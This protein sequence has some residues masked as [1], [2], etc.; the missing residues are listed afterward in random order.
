MPSR[1]RVAIPALSSHPQAASRLTERI[2]VLLADDHAVL[3]Q[4]TAELLRREPDLE[5]VGEAAD[6]QQAVELT[7]SLLPDVVVM[8]VRMP[9]LSGIQATRLIR[10][11][12]PKT[13]VLVLTAHEDDEY[14]FSLLREGA[15]GYLLKTSPVQE[16]ISAIRLVHHGESPLDP[17][18]A[19]KLVARMVGQGD[20]T[21]SDESAGGSRPLLT[22]REMQVLELVARGMINKGIAERL[23]ISDRTVQAHLTNI[24][25]KMKVSSRV[26]A[27]LSAIRQGWLVLER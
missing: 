27:V 4:G 3:R 10:E 1:R 12:T 15:S 7:Q 26:E 8:D 19:K 14:V 23:G 18:I 11:R 22:P 17:A 2:T 6:G 9:V 20:I 24:F 21:A 25:D 13:R 5:V 16:L